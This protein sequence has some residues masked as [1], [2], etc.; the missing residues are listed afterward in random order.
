MNRARCQ[1]PRTIAVVVSEL[2][3]YEEGLFQQPLIFTT[4]SFV[5][6]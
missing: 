2:A 6:V 4:G 1:L 3:V 5:N